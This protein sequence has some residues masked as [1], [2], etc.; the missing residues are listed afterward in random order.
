MFCIYRLALVSL[1]HYLTL[2]RRLSSES[3]GWFVLFDRPSTCFFSC[4]CSCSHL[5]LLL[6]LS[7]LLC[8]SSSELSKQPN[9]TFLL[10]LSFFL[11]VRNATPVLKNFL[12][13]LKK[14]IE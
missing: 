4:C 7:L 12:I 10:F 6:F 9:N 3:E 13:N 14:E 5:L 2:D 8:I 11:C 1:S